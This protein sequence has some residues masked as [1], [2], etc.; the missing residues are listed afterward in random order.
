MGSFSRPR[1]TFDWRTQFPPAIRGL[2]LANC[3]VYVAEKFASLA[4]GPGI[5]R[6]LIEWFGLIPYAVVHGLRVWQLATYL[7]LHEGL[8]H[9]LLNM[10]TLW[11][12]APDLERVWGFRRFLTYYFVTGI[13]AGVCVVLVN[14]IPEWLGHAP[15]LSVTIGASGAL[16][17]ILMACALLF[18]DRQV[19]LIPLPIMMPMR[20]FVLV[21]G[22]IAFFSSLEGA[23]DGISHIAHLG[24]LLVGYLYLRRGSMFFTARNRYLDWKQRR[25]RR[26]FEVYQREHRDEP[27][28]NP[29]RWVH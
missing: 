20:L 25:L 2:I 11:F 9:L 26:K 17:G 8:W 19:W 13:G 10:L 23:S 4:F 5:E 24:G 29:G 6:G 21:W 27:P 14:V 3:G 18:P 12:F 28:E 15:R 1:I 16:F 22:A 7:F